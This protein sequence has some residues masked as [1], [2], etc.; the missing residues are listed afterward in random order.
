MTPLRL[1]IGAWL[2]L[3]D[4]GSSR[5]VECRQGG[6]LSASRPRGWAGRAGG[7]VRSAARRIGLVKIV[8]IGSTQILALLAGISRDGMVM[9]GGMFA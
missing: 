5:P 7:R 6:T 4:R 9:V 3:L 1:K 8:L 2:K